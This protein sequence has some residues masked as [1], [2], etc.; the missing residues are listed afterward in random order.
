M[1]RIISTILTISMLFTMIP[2]FASDIE[3]SDV[4]SNLQLFSVGS[5]EAVVK[6]S[7]K[8]LTVKT[9][10]FEEQEVGTIS[11]ADGKTYYGTDFL[12]YSK[13]NG[14][15]ETYSVVEENGNKY[16]KLDNKAGGYTTNS[17]TQVKYT[18]V[19][20]KKVYL[21]YKMRF[22]LP[23]T[24]W[25]SINING[26][27]GLMSGSYVDRGGFG[28]NYGGDYSA[29]KNPAAYAK[30]KGAVNKVFDVETGVWYTM[31]YIFDL[32]KKTYDF[33]VTSDK[34]DVNILLTTKD[35][36]D[37]L[38]DIPFRGVSRT[39]TKATEAIFYVPHNSSDPTK[40]VANSF[41]LDDIS[42]YASEKGLFFQLIG[43]ETLTDDAD[44]RI[45]YNN[46]TGADKDVCVTYVAFED[47]VVFDVD[48]DI[49]KLPIDKNTADVNVSVDT[50]A[51]TGVVT[52][53][54]FVTDPATGGTLCAEGSKTGTTVPADFV[55]VAEANGQINVSVAKDSAY[56]AAVIRIYD[57]D[58]NLVGIKEKK[59]TSN[60][61]ISFDIK[62]YNQEYTAD[63]TLTD[64]VGNCAYAEDSII[65]WNPSIADD[66]N[67]DPE[68]AFVTHMDALN[69]AYEGFEDI[70]NANPDYINNYIILRNDY[71]SVHDV[72][73]TV[74]SI[75]GFLEVIGAEDEETFA[76]ALEANADSIGI[77]IDDFYY[78]NKDAIIGKLFAGKEDELY[79]LPEELVDAYNDIYITTEFNVAPAISYGRLFKKYAAILGIA[80]DKTYTN[81][82]ATINELIFAA[83]E[84]NGCF[85][86]IADV[87]ATFRS[88]KSNAVDPVGYDTVAV[89]PLAKSGLLIDLEECA[90]VEGATAATGVP[91]S[92]GKKGNGNFSIVEENGNKFVTVTQSENT[93]AE[94]T[95][96]VFDVSSIKGDVVYVEY[97]IRFEKQ[98]DGWTML[99]LSDMSSLY[100]SGKKFSLNETYK[101]A[102]GKSQGKTRAISGVT[103]PDV[104]Y[105][106]K[107]SIDFDAQTY[108]ITIVD[109][110]GNEIA[111]DDTKPRF[112]ATK[113]YTDPG[114]LSFYTPQNVDDEYVV[115]YDNVR[116]YTEPTPAVY[117]SA[118]ALKDVVAGSNGMAVAVENL[119]GEDRA[120]GVYVPVY[121]DG[122]LYTMAFARDY[123]MN[124][125]EKE[126]IIDYV[127]PADVDTSKVTYSVIV[128]DGFD[129][130]NH[131]VTSATTE[132]VLSVDATADFEKDIINVTTDSTFDNGT[133]IVLAPGAT[134]ANAIPSDI[135]Y[136]AT[137]K[138][139]NVK[140][141][142]GIKGDL[143]VYAVAQDAEGKVTVA[144]DTVYY[145]GNGVAKNLVSDFSEVTNETV[146]SVV[147][148]YMDIINAVEPGM[149][150]FYNE[151]SA[152][153]DAALVANKPYATTEEVINTI[154]SVKAL[155]ALKVAASE[156]EF[157]AAFNEFATM[158]DVKF[159]DIYTSNKAVFIATMYSEK[160]NF[161]TYEDIM[162]AYISVY[163]VFDINT[164][165]E[166]IISGK[167][168]KYADKLGITLDDV[169]KSK[170]AYIDR[171]V[172]ADA[173]FA[174]KAEI[175]SSYNNAYT[176][177]EA[178]E[179]D[180]VNTVVSK[181]PINLAGDEFTFDNEPI[182]SGTKTYES[183]DGSFSI[184]STN[185]GGEY[186][187][188][189]D[190]DNRY[191]RLTAP[192]N[193]KRA[194]ELRI[195]AADFGDKVEIS[196]SFKAN[197]LSNWILFY[198]GSNASCLNVQGG[199][200]LENWG[201]EKAPSLNSKSISAGVWYKVT[202]LF[203]VNAKKYDLY[204]V[205]RDN[206]SDVIVNVKGVDCRN[207]NTSAADVSSITFTTSSENSS[208]SDV[209][210]DNITRRTVPESGL[211]YTAEAISTLL[212][213]K[214]AVK[215]SFVNAD[216]FNRDVN[217]YVP[218]YVDGKL[219]TVN[220]IYSKS[221]EVGFNGKDSAEI[222]VP[223]ELFNQGKVSYK[224]FVTEALDKVNYA[225][226]SNAVLPR[227]T[228]VAEPVADYTAR[229]I[230]VSGTTTYDN[231]AILVTAPTANSSAYD[232]A[233]ANNN[234]D[235][236]AYYNTA[237]LKEIS[238]VDDVATD[239]RVATSNFVADIKIA[240]KFINGDYYVYFI[241]QNNAGEV[242]VIR[243]SVY[244]AGSDKLDDMLADFNA[245]TDVNAET[246]INTYM[247]VL[248]GV[249]SD[250][251]AFYAANKAIVNEAIVAG[252]PYANVGAVNNTIFAIYAA[253]KLKNAADVDTFKSTL[254]SYSNVFAIDVTSAEY[255]AG[256]AEINNRL[257]NDRANITKLNLG[258]KYANALMLSEFNNAERDEVSAVIA[259]YAST[260]GVDVNSYDYVTYIEGISKAVAADGIVFNSVADIT[261]AINDG[262]AYGKANGTGNAPVPSAPA[263]GGGGGGGGGGA[264]APTEKVYFDEPYVEA[265]KTVE[266]NAAN[267]AAFTDLDTVSWAKE[268]IT[269]LKKLGVINGVSTT[270]FA[271]NREVTRE[272]FAK[273]IV[274]A[275][276]ITGEGKTFAD[277]P[278][279]AWYAP[280]VT[281]LASS[282]IVNGVTETKFGVG[283]K[284]TRQD[285]AVI[286][287]RV[288]LKSIPSEY[289]YDYSALN[290]F[291][292]YIADYAVDSIYR[293]FQ[294]GVIN[295]TS[296]TTFSA[297][298]TLTRAQAAKMIYSLMQL[299]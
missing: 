240:D 157:E 58:E 89:S 55:T 16:I 80:V 29:E 93:G 202:W 249:A 256:A 5:G 119:T 96:I 160:E 183:Q 268:A 299:K 144:N 155:K 146:A 21:T 71:T 186:F 251:D 106:V 133:I 204:I 88:A 121:V 6:Q 132:G 124:G 182:T 191:V 250:M 27:G 107:Y 177:A 123:F 131:S 60:A 138:T 102:D 207:S 257:F 110:D 205:N 170:Q 227:T 293:L 254:E 210:F 235:V 59:I 116:A 192:A 48:E 38:K 100:L 47:G 130:V 228:T 77:V 294:N 208:E 49:V 211:H 42:S 237:D 54:A 111:N 94:T 114:K 56:D 32:D 45:E 52:Y 278:A 33:S 36:S 156:A 223:A 92:F 12:L 115:S 75:G 285:A 41:S 87:A 189:Q 239:E 122:V 287:D 108:N 164:A 53:E 296:A 261:S 277:V 30:Y 201:K 91:F 51:C 175:V 50:S 22:D 187:I 200:F 244:Y 169:Y 226:L 230:K 288:A 265:E 83:K 149:A 84:E 85:E 213:G 1:K 8:Q 222:D 298:A 167:L 99:N 140:V 81:G 176:K 229:T 165:T 142:D 198:I 196:T 4:N 272:E 234:A 180:F 105:T 76:A 280:Y 168:V 199:K 297:T 73:E 62:N 260:L 137:G 161:N 215:F 61:P 247:D 262:I 24:D 181:S 66:F 143:K 136:Y 23:A 173:P 195:P 37:P 248:L 233:D 206:P 154:K 253:D 97:Q 79:V 63:V 14:G 26:D 271:P 163:M 35:G 267:Q 135:L 219:A 236:I 90:L 238:F 174:D 67:A 104:W 117:Y 134:L 31:N 158:F 40:T 139:A 128:A 275:F 185:V 292:D 281:A 43:A 64:A 224:V 46:T 95:G 78:V 263:G 209:V 218:V 68:T 11:V 283:S 203:D 274:N 25:L 179:G 129:G 10:D 39:Y 147:T 243:K 72:V 284:I 2:A 17:S 34:G 214:N 286:L 245:V 246:T 86:D 162:D 266:G 70:Y 109:E 264:P 225:T 172:L 276:S 258:N 148:G 193:T 44:M 153:V 101:D 151:N 159:D 150:T 220:K 112:F 178:L 188:E 19:S 13:L 295:G 166:D 241:S 231:M 279:T 232:I 141:A 69:R 273:M 171:L 270:E 290:M 126:L 252:K 269:E 190:G 217:V 194:L 289:E 103:S 212:P 259:K 221:I 291:T 65:V 82:E 120:I 125:V 28:F 113:K 152:D 255:L 184:A 15:T 216:N 98:S 9:A 197:K 145:P 242:K 127:L 282:G 118:K 3:T 7:A 20:G 74:I 57:E 18:F